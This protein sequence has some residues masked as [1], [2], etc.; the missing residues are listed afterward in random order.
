MSIER[1]PRN[2]SSEM[3]EEQGDALEK[4]LRTSEQS[5]EKIQTIEARLGEWRRALE[6]G[7]PTAEEALAIKEKLERVLD[8]IRY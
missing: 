1:T 5:R 4:H 8:I 3:A 7:V 2:T 6:S